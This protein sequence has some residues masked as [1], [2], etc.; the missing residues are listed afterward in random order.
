MPVAGTLKMREELL[1]SGKQTSVTMSREPD[2]WF[3]AIAVEVAMTVE[4]T[5]HASENQPSQLC[6]LPGCEGHA[7]R[8]GLPVRSWTCSR[9]NT[10]ITV[11]S[12]QQ[13]LW[14]TIGR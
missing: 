12:M 3:A 4:H 5:V 6:S 9:C 8:R 11:I 7:V 1:S 10:P 2:R 14:S 13:G